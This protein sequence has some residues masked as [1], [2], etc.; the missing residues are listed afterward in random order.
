MNVGDKAHAALR[1]V[2]ALLAE[3]EFGIMF[4]SWFLFLM[5]FCFMLFPCNGDE[6]VRLLPIIAGAW[7]GFC[8]LL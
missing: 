6:Q 3:L 7:L 1:V 8:F 4:P 2:Y 5:A